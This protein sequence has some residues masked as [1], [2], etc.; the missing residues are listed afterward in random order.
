MVA[1]SSSLN[2]NASTKPFYSCFVGFTLRFNATVSFSIKFL[3]A[4]KILDYLDL[5]ELIV[6]FLYKLLVLIP[7]FYL[8]FLM[9]RGC[10]A[11]KLSFEDCTSKDVRELD[12][13]DPLDPIFK[14]TYDGEFVWNFRSFFYGFANFSRAL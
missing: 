3:T 5:S 6:K 10:L 12:S 9:S 11:L 1:L 4:F 13:Y 14:E 7:Y 8:S 2:S